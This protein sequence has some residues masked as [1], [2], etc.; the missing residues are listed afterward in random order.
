MPDRW[1]KTHRNQ[2]RWKHD[3]P[4]RR[5]QF[6][7]LAENMGLY[8]VYEPFSSKKGWQMDPEPGCPW[9]HEFPPEMAPIVA[10]LETKK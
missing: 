9:C 8:F 2:W 7:L 10:D 4:A 1:H 5:E 6:I 3:C